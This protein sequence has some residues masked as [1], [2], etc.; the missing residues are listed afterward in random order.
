MEKKNNKKT[1]KKFRGDEESEPFIRY[2]G[3]AE[4]AAAEPKASEAKKSE[5][6]K[7]EAK[8]SEKKSEGKSSEEEIDDTHCC[9]KYSTAIMIYGIFLWLFGILIICN[10][11]V[12]F[13]NMYFPWYYPFVSLLLS[14]VYFAGLI[15]I[16]IFWC[17]DS[18]STRTGLKIGGWLIL[19]SLVAL[20]L[21]NI[22]FI[23]NYAKHKS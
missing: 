21:W 10:N 20:V 18:E 14:I 16:A 17:S 4:E 22:F 13:A 9:C 7:S 6:K 3:G 5:A 15:L 19:G 2:E 23:L 8:K 1:L 12:E 11:L